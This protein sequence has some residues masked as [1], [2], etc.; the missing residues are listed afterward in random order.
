[1]T[2]P[3]DIKKQKGSTE[4]FNFCFEVFKLRAPGKKMNDQALGD[5][6]GFTPSDTSH[7]KRGK[8]EIKSIYLLKRL[9]DFLDLDLHILQDL[10]SKAIGYEEAWFDFSILEEERKF[11]SRATSEMLL[12]RKEKSEHIS[13]ISDIIREKSNITALPIYLPELVGSFG[14]IGL[15]AKTIPGKLAKLFRIKGNEFVI[16]YKKG[17]L[18]VFVRFAI[19]YEL[20]KSIILLERKNWGLGEAEE[21]YQTVEI[22]ELAKHLLVPKKMFFDE[23]K[24]QRGHN[25]LVDHLAET[26]W[27]PHSIIRLQLNHLIQ[28]RLAFEDFSEEPLRVREKNNVSSALNKKNLD[29]RFLEEQNRAG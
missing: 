26:F 12:K 8:K 3:F 10:A 5:A 18:N 15:I 1:M 2:K 4:L 13:K 25:K 21:A 20:A 24:K 6:L 9:A 7:W 19:A 27:V 16:R 17:D 14:N 29:F 23:I 28:E 11:L 22:I